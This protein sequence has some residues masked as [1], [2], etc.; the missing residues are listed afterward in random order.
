M[1][2]EKLSLAG[3]RGAQRCPQQAGWSWRGGPG[4]ASWDMACLSRA[5]EGDE[6]S[7]AWN[8][9]SCT[10]RSHCWSESREVESEENPWESRRARS[11]QVNFPRPR[12]GAI[13]PSAQLRL[14]IIIIT[15]RCFNGPVLRAHLNHSDQVSFFPIQR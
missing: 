9:R 13:L 2:E 12:V 14:Q 4:K 10:Y 8:I 7:W 15:S 5:Q 6:L 1:A 11:L 3:R